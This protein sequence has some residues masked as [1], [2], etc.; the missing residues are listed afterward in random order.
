MSDFGIGGIQIRDVQRVALN[1]PVRKVVRE[2]A[3]VALRELIPSAQARPA[4]A[5]FEEF[6]AESQAQL[7]VLRQ[8]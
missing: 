3:D 1:T 6:I 7:R 5:T 2:T 8:L 4:I